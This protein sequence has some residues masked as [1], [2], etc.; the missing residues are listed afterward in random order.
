MVDEFLFWHNCLVGYVMGK[1]PTFLWLKEILEKLWKPTG[2]FEMQSME[3]VLS[4][5]D[6]IMKLVATI[7]S[8]T[9]GL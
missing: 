5:F 2:T 6:F 7:F 4:C 8:L 3:N 1:Q 9:F